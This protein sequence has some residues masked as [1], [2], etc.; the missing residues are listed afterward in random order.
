MNSLPFGLCGEGKAGSE[1]SNYDLAKIFQLP[2]IITILEA[3][4]A[5]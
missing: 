4:R 2:T 3:G 5:E 1:K